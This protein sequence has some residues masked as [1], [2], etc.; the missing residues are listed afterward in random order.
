MIRQHAQE[1]F[2]PVQYL[3]LQTV[4]L[5]LVSLVGTVGLIRLI[6]NGIVQPLQSLTEAAARIAGG[7]LN[8]P[9]PLRRRDEIGVLAPAS[10]G[11]RTSSL[12]Q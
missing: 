9:I 7:D 1:L 11:C 6:T 3:V 12:I 2:T 10:T 5:G 8:T 4:F